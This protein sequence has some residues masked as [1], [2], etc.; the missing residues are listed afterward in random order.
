MLCEQSLFVAVNN[1]CLYLKYENA[2]L[3]LS[4]Q[5]S[6]CLTAISVQKALVMPFF[7]CDVQ[8]LAD[9]FRWTGGILT[10]SDN[11]L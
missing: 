5:L 4:A 11:F 1:F 2:E 3:V 6:L 8:I 9:L 10:L 7:F